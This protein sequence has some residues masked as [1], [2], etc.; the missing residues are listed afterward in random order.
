[1]YPIKFNNILK[2]RMWGGDAIVKK[3]HR[4]NT[5]QE[6]LIGESWDIVDRDDDQS[7]VVNGSLAGL[8]LAEL[9]TKHSKM[10]G[11]KFNANN[12]FPI[13]VKILDAKEDLSLQVH[14]R[15]ADL[16]KLAGNP[17]SKS[18]F[19]Y[20]LDHTD[21]AKIMAGLKTGVSK[22]DFVA[23]LSSYNLLNFLNI[24]ESRDNRL[25]YV[26][27]GT[28]HA[29]GGGNLILE[30]QENSD[31]TYRVS[32]WGRLDSNG[33]PRE[34]HVDNSL[35]CIDF[36]NPQQAEIIDVDIAKDYTV[37]DSA[38][39]TTANYGITQDFS[40]S[41]NEESCCLLSLANGRAEVSANGESVALNKG[42][43]I[44]LPANLAFKITNAGE[45]P[46]NILITTPKY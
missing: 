4:E 19:W 14:P 12:P 5:I 27:S 16:P 33:K 10:F 44:L 39:F 9:R 30:I 45:N 28:L 38:Y 26:E 8:S 42:D 21:S 15:K 29:I 35:Q 1:M 20:I 25:I 17:Q 41:T 23:N 43:T 40:F 46:A 34:I 13:L 11:S 36:E 2:Y 7:I 6:N 18:E 31:T 3:L 22:K 24:E 32:D 37:V